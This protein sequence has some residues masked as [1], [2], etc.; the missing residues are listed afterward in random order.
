MIKYSTTFS[1]PNAEIAIF[2]NTLEDCTYYT[3]DATESTDTVLLLRNV[4]AH[5]VAPGEGGLGDFTIPVGETNLLETSATG[6]LDTD[7][8]ILDSYLTTNGYERGV[9]GHEI[10]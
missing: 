3:V 7:G 8:T 5:D 4:A 6:F 10:A 9:Y 2:R 1:V